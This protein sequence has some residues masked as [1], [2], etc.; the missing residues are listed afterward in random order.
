M[1]AV[2]SDQVEAMRAYLTGDGDSY[3]QMIDQ[4][5]A[6]ARKAHAALIIAS[7]IMAADRR[8]GKGSTRADVTE[9]VSNLR[10]RSEQLADD[11]D[12]NQA[13]RLIM[14]VHTGE[15]IDDIDDGLYSLLLAGLIADAQL[16]DAELDEFLDNARDLADQMLGS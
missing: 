4:F 14:A 12:Q 13:E 11:I 10:S 9:F 16:S 7:F 15:D 8:F 6:T 1:K 3:K 5:D 2:T